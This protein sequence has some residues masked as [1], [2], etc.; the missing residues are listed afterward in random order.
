MLG[1][2]QLPKDLRRLAENISELPR[3]L[4]IPISDLWIALDEAT[5]AGEGTATLNLSPYGAVISYAYSQPHLARLGT[6]SLT[7]TDRTKETHHAGK[8]PPSS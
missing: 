1:L 2:G 6:I 4:K 7:Q 3:L 5:K 8:A